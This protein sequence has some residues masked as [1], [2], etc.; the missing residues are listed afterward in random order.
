MTTRNAAIFYEADGFKTNGNRLLGRQAAGESFLKGF[1]L[2]SGVEVFHGFT[3]HPGKFKMFRDQVQGYLKK[4]AEY[5]WIS[6]NRIQ[7]LSQ[8]GSLFYSGPSIAPFAW[9]RRHFNAGSFSLCGLTHTTCSAEAMQS[10]ADL[11]TGPVEEWDA[12]IC[13]SHSVR[14]TAEHIHENWAEYLKERTGGKPK[15]RAQLPVIPLGINCDDFEKTKATAPFVKKFKAEHGIND[16]DVVFLFV[17]RLASH[18]KAHPLPMYHALEKA[19]QKTSKKIHLIQAGWFAS[20]TIGEVFKQ[21]AEEFC[22][23]VNAIFIDGRLPA[24]RQHIWHV[25]DVFTTL[26][27]NIQE[28]F[29]ITPIEAMAAGLPVVA[30]DWDGYRETMRDGAESLLVKTQMPEAGSGI[31][32]SYRYSGGIDSYDRYIGQASLFT[33]VDTDHCAAQYLDLIEND[34]KRQKMGQA[35]YEYVRKTFDWSVLVPKYQDL[36]ADLAARRP[37]E[38]VGV[39]RCANPLVDDPFATFEHYPTE[40]ITA[41]SILEYQDGAAGRVSQYSKHGLTRG[42][43]HMLPDDEKLEALL[44]TL[45]SEGPKTVADAAILLGTNPRYTILFAGW[46]AKMDLVKIR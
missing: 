38:P 32:L 37:K 8:A 11:I 12:L 25:A 28:T 19:A 45:S 23:S 29:G 17:G 24:V 21:G 40:L 1:A 10:I 46:L 5:N 22:P 36:W 13:T 20:P 7:E 33:N 26:S 9:Q 18:A 39:R 27:D 43:S 6:A 42:V 2:H 34:E 31:A 30:T 16:G 15:V 4:P 14:K 41:K 35:G 3:D 44:Q